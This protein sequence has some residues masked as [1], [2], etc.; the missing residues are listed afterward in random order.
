MRCQL[1]QMQPARGTGCRVILVLL[2][3]CW[4]DGCPPV[5]PP[6]W[7]PCASWAPPHVPLYRV[8]RFGT[9]SHKP[10]AQQNPCCGSAAGSAVSLGPR[11]SHARGCRVVVAPGPHLSGPHVM[12]RSVMAWPAVAGVHPLSRPLLQ[13]VASIS[14]RG[15]QPTVRWRWVEQTCGVPIVGPVHP[16][17]LSW[18]WASGFQPSRVTLPGR[19]GCRTVKELSRGDYPPVPGVWPGRLSDL[20]N[21][22]LPLAYIVSYSQVVVNSVFV[23]C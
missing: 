20:S 2:C 8:S 1:H 14:S 16:R 11:A 4:A 6:S 19:L 12:P 15:G 21:S 17:P 3:S 7:L 13:R 9:R 23:S 10:A 22:L 18:P 5:H